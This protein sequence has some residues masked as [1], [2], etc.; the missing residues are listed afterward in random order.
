[1]ETPP[2]TYRCGNRYQIQLFSDSLDDCIA[3]G[4]PVRAY[5]AFVD[6]LDLPNLKFEMDA[7][8]A[9]NPEYHPRTMLKLLIYGYSY[10]HQ[11][12]RKLER[13]VHHN[14]SFM[15]LMGG[16]KPDHKTIARFRSDN[17]KAIKNVLK[18]CAQMCI[19][20]GL[21]EGN[22][23]FVDGSKFRAS[24]SI[25]QTWT[26]ERCEKV[27]KKVDTRID[28]ILA[29]CERIDKQ[30]QDSPSLVKLKE[31][32]HDKETLKAKVEAV[33]KEI[34]D[35][36]RR[37]INTTDPECV[38]VKGRQGTHAGY[39]AQI[40]VDEKHGLIVNSD[41][42]N[43]SNDINQFANQINQAQKNL[44]KKCQASCGDAGYSNTDKMKEI[45]DQNIAVIVPTQKQAYDTPA[46]EFEKSQFQYDADKDCYTC[47]QGHSLPYSYFCKDKQHRVYQI[48]NPSNCTG[49]PHFGV[50][51]KDKSG[52]RV[53]RLVNEETRLKLE[54][55]YKKPES[56][57]IYKLRKEKVELPFGHIKHNLRTGGF[58]LRGLDGVNAEMSI[59]TSCFNIARMIGILGVVPLIAKLAG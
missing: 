28:G 55:Q 56:Q 58:L 51:T 25:N 35:H 9:G 8:K 11:S 39:N 47:P 23:L 45:D 24:A 30:E 41:V 27:L 12:S 50:C 10:G 33:H 42:V 38:K 21:I 53:R 37:S 26:A 22:T 59:L 54:A 3:K 48:E 29:E 52:R 13:A 43:E 6:L 40:V 36:D 2:M 57:A 18:Q 44:D 31:E 46:K 14:I 4:D 32:L 49:C 1:M 34:K 20:L 5:D 17:K 16:L 15:W 7:H 19:K